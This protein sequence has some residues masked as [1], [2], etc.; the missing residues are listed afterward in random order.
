MPSAGRPRS[1]RRPVCQAKPVLPLIAACAVTAAAWAYLLAGHGG[2]WRTDQRLPAAAGL[3][4][5]WPGVVAVVPARDEAAVLAGTLPA[6]LAQDYPGAFDVV[7]VDDES[8]DG[9]AQVAAALGRAAGIGDD[10]ARRPGRGLRIVSGTRTPAGWAGKV[11]AMAQGL[12]TVGDAEYV[13]F[14]DADIAC[15]PGSL[16]MLVQAAEADDRA[17]VSQM[18]LLR[19]DTGWER[20]LVPAFVYFFAQL[21]PFRRV[22]RPG[23]RTAAA[24]GGCMLVRRRELMAAGGLDGIRGALIDDVA[25]GRL[26][27]GRRLTGQPPKASA[28]AGR[29]WL[30]LST[31]ITS[32]RPY[33]RLADVWD[34]VARSA[35]TQL[36]YSPAALA[37]TVAGL[38]WLYVLPPAAVLAGLTGLAAGGGSAFGWLAAAGLVSWALMTM[39]YVPMLRLY[40]LSPLRAPCLPLIAVLYAAMTVDSAR[41]HR[42]G[43][44]GE[45]KGRVVA[46]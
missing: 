17:L 21:Y 30:G 46:D 25:L 43:R 34:M 41:R 26:M 12:Q 16:T 9:T 18:A 3:P 20:L 13:L 14:T 33:P 27:K 31:D 22:N 2:Y 24:A 37:G 29:C 1:G 15:R 8:S 6:L 45:W 4:R 10:Q 5:R 44:S 7:L 39:T 35:Y 42:A 40:G 28:S 38:L 23:A 19:A 11:W 36:R 32:V